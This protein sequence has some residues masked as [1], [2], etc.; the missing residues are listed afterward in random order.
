MKAL[1]EIPICNVT[2]LENIFIPLSD[3]CQLAARIWMPDDAA[4]NPVP[5]IL[6]YLPYRKRDGTLDRDEMTHPYFAAHGYACIRVDMRGNGESDG[7]MFDEYLKQEQDDALEV[8]DWITG[9]A[10]C[11]GQVGMIGISWG[12]FNGLQVA[13]LRPPALK[14]VVSICSTDD[15]YADDVH[16]M[17]GCLLNCNLSWATNMMAYS[18]RPPDPLLVGEKWRDIWL[19]RLENLPFLAEPWTEHQLRDDYWKH[20]SICEDYE[21]VEAAVLLVSGWADGY[22]NTVF[23]MMENLKC[24]KKALVGPWAHKYPHFAKPGP[25][26]GFLQ[27]CLKW[28]DRWLKG[29]PVVDKK[30][31]AVRLYMQESRPPKAEYESVPGRWIGE[32]AWP[33]PTIKPKRFQLGDHRLQEQPGK[34]EVKIASPQ[35]NGSRG[36]RWFTFGTGPE[37]PLDQMED[38]HLSVVFDSAPLD[39][40]MEICGAP[41]L[42]VVLTPDK[43]SALLA[44]RLCDLRPDGAIARISYGV[45]N[46]THLKSHESPEAL[47]P[48]V[49]VEVRLQL[50]EV[51]WSLKAGHKIRLSLS[52]AYWPLVWPSPEATSLV[53]DLAKSSLSIPVRP[54]GEDPTISFPPAE[55]APLLK[56]TV[57]RPAR[58]DWRIE[59]VAK[60]GSVITH[61]LDDYGE[62]IISA[63]GLR[64]SLI[65]KEKYSISPDDPLSAR[66]EINWDVFVGRD[67]WQITAKVE[68]VMWSD[69]NWFYLTAN[70]KAYEFGK[71]LVFS[72]AWQKKIKRTP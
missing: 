49:P 63:H 39:E 34:G 66:A 55:S 43:P 22:S 35:T 42:S 11:S 28:W 38:D 56:Q 33:S 47:T 69:E 41:V 3:G 68:T 57:I 32:P 27:E 14:A 53:I 12:G 7:L 65:G 26:V 13:A 19:N 72:K 31:E 8:I 54:S 25:Q 71:M 16:Y 61:N 20:A 24:P 6:E 18:V 2:E 60:D 64:T 70:L 58:L 23:R 37:Q 1:K 21:S 46:L 45:I 9:Q 44:A 29:K 40:T 10:W 15:R 50:N 62:R 17:G 5:A 4:Q 36:G 30:D 48:G 51:A 67:D 52:N 59:T